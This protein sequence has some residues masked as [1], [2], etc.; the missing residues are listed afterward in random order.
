MSE[1]D[2]FGQTTRLTAIPSQWIRFKRVDFPA[3]AGGGDDPFYVDTTTTFKQRKYVDI[4]KFPALTDAQAT[5]WCGI[6]FSSRQRLRRRLAE[7][8]PLCARQRRQLDAEEQRW[9]LGHQRQPDDPDSNV[10]VTSTSTGHE[11]Y[12]WQRRG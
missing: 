5:R 1:P 9:H 10:F 2:E 7:M 6:R 12:P 3:P 11:D 4:S 8:V